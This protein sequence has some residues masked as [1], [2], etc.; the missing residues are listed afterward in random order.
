LSDLETENNLSR[1]LTALDLSDGRRVI[2]I[3]T[4]H[5]SRASVNQVEE[6]IRAESPDHVCVEIDATRYKSLVEESKWSS[7]NITDVLKKRQ[8]FLLLANMV[9]SSFQKRMG[10]EQGISPGDEMKA[11]INVCQELDIPFSFADREIHVTLRRAWNKSGLWQKM[12]LMASMLASFFSQEKLSAEEIEKLKSKSAMDDMMGELADYLPTVKT[13]LV[14]ERDQYLAATIFRAEGKKIIAVVGAAHA[15]GIKD[16]L[17]ALDRKER[18]PGLE[19]ISEVPPP[20]I[21]SRLIPWLIPAVIAG[22]L[23]LGF[24]RFGKNVGF[25]MLAVWILSNGVLA[26]VGSLLALAHPVSIIS[27]FIAA[28][29]TSMVPTIGVGMVTG[30]LEYYLRRPRVAD[31]EKL[32]QD[33]L[34]L[35]G[36]YRNR[37]AHI[38]LV[39]L[40]ST[41]GSSAGTFIALPIIVKV[42]G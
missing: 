37:V 8:G 33:I 22:L 10:Q 4:A 21:F 27:A 25:E 20:G 15:G 34:G 17:L 38:F 19:S 39:F 16:W 9:L 28:P 7:L 23:V 12:K 30:I 11:A 42:I 14:D 35:K 1:G 24:V 32:N 2:L 36:F 41:L 26:A 29:V 18:S 13:I 40:L 31:F 3:G 6:V 5:I